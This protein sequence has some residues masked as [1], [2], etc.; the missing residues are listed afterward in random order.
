[1]AVVNKVA[2]L[3]DA[4]MVDGHIELFGCQQ[5]RQLLPRPAVKLPF[6]PLAVGIFGGIEAAVRMRHVAEH[7]CENVADDFRVA[8]LAGDEIRVEVELCQLRVV[9]EHLLEMRHEP[10]GVHGVTGEA[11]AELVVNAARCMRSQVCST[12]RV[13]SGIVEAFGVAQQKPRLAR[14]GN[15]GAPP[16]TAVA[17]VVMLL[18]QQA[19]L[20]Q[21]S[22]GQGQVRNRWRRQRLFQPRVNVAGRTVK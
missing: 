16:K 22:G 9:V 18:Q 10:F 4:E 6:V 21:D 11:A 5:L 13:A 1:V 20:A 2:L 3:R 17:R 8:R 19:G 7:V 15:F 12:L 14:L